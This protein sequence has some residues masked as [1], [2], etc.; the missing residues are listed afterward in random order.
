MTKSTTKK[1][2]K[3]ILQC[4]KILNKQYFIIYVK[5]LINVIHHIDRKKW[6]KIIPSSHSFQSVSHS[7]VPDSLQPHGL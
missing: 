3:A 2:K 7:V 1:K 5:K 6:E 4:C